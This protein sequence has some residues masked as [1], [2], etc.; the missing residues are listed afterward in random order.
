MIRLLLARNLHLI[1]NWFQCHDQKGH[2]PYTKWFQ[3]K[4]WI[5]ES[6][7][8]KWFAIQCNFLIDYIHWCGV[9]HASF[10]VSF[11]VKKEGGFEC[12]R[13]PQ[14]NRWGLFE[15]E[16]NQ[17]QQTPSSCWHP[18]LLVALFS[19][20]LVD[21]VAQNYQSTW[22]LST[23]GQCRSPTTGVDQWVWVYSSL[24]LFCDTT[25]N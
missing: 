10:H 5:D 25:Y 17:H 19:S 20:R 22:A 18:T 11:V 6:S 13:G 21:S 4:P 24:I 2:Q 7:V 8:I 3:Q 15:Q 23:L 9:R 12:M 1:L 16:E 14:E